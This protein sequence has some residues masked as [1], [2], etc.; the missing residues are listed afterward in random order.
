MSDHLGLTTPARPHG[1]A[2]SSM[3]PLA[4]PP[5]QGLRTDHENIFV[6]WCCVDYRREM[7]MS[8]PGVYHRRGIGR[9]TLISTERCGTFHGRTA[10]CVYA[11]V[12]CHFNFRVDG[13]TDDISPWPGSLD[14]RLQCGANIMRGAATWVAC[15]K[16]RPPQN[17]G[18]QRCR[19]RS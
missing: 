15:P 6:C 8:A 10:D 11:Y 4:L 12:Y 16:T 17:R 3:P 9:R 5:P 19:Q 13:D 2:R 14:G 7:S 18:G 1:A